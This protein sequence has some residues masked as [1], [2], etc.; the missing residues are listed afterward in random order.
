MD[1]RFVKAGLLHRVVFIHLLETTSPV[2]DPIQI[3]Q[4]TQV[5]RRINKTKERQQNTDHQPDICLDTN[6][7]ESP[8]ASHKRPPRERARAD[9]LQLE[10]SCVK[11]LCVRCL[12]VCVCMCAG[13]WIYFFQPQLLT[14]SQ[15]QSAPHLYSWDVMTCNYQLHGTNTCQQLDKLMISDD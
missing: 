2:F 12:P 6:E 14:T 15:K 4:L 8:A 10:K 9:F 7:E 1:V 11:P 3:K 5:T 13:M